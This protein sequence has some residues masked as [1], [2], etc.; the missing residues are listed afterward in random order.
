[1]DDIRGSL[2]KMKKK[3]KHLLAGKKR[4]PDGAATNPGEEGAGSASSV[5]QPEPHIVM[6]GSYDGEGD[7]ADAAG[8]PVFSTDQP[9]QPDGP[10]S[11]PAHGSDDGQ[12]GGEPG[13]DGGEAGQMDSYAHPDAEAAAGRGHSGELEGVHPSPSAPSISHDGESDGTWTWSF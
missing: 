12:E 13:V 1:M 10:E 5:P 6:G 11:V 4:K 2:S 9:P 7:R 8:E 3:A